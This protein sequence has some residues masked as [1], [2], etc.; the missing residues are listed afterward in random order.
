MGY[1]LVGQGCAASSKSF[2]GQ[3]TVAEN[4]PSRA[5]LATYDGWHTATLSDVIAQADVVVITTGVA[6]VLS[7]AMLSQLKLGTFVMNV[8]H[9]SHEI[10]L[11]AMTDYQ[12][13][14]ILPEIHEYRNAEYYFYTL[15]NGAMFNLT[16][17]YGDS[18]NAFVYL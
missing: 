11:D 4:D 2:G 5:L 15:S 3:V 12:V 9:V 8:G 17:G 6:G 18:L 7:K 1:G 10:R 16:A 14:E 13:D